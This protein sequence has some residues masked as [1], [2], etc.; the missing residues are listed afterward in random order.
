MGIAKDFFDENGYYVARNVFAGEELENLQNDFNIIVDQLQEHTENANARWSSADHIADSQG[1]VVVHTHQVQAYSA[2]WNQAFHQK[3]FLDIT[4]DIIGPDIILHHSKLFHK[5][6][7]NGAPF[8]LHQDY[9]YFPTVCDSMIAAVILI[10][11]STEDR[12]C[13]RI[14]PGSHKLGR[15]EPGFSINHNGDERQK[16][17]IAEHPLESAVPMIGKAGDVIFFH[18]FTLHG[19]DV[20]RSPFDRQS[21]LVQMHAG[22][23]SMETQGHPYSGD[24]LRGHNWAMTRDRANSVSV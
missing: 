22:D 17:F 4:E 9:P 10:S 15:L 2:Y 20:N 19:S 8:P 12:G 3:Q 13:I 5:P 24:V 7:G 18:Y 23:D 11:D 1:T 21:V 6:A 16:E 14:V